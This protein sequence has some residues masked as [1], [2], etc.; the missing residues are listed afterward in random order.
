MSLNC[1]EGP[2][3]HVGVFCGVSA[4]LSSSSPFHGQD[5]GG[6]Y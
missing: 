6:C 5:M 1:F 4:G 2:R 3:S